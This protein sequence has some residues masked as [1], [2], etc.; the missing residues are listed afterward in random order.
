M[1]KFIKTANLHLLISTSIVVPAAIIYGFQ[2]A[3][4]FD[5]KL[6]TT[7]EQN[8]FKAI[9]GLYLAFA[10]VW[11]IGVFD[12]KYWKTA[13]I[14]NIFFMF[15][16]AFGRII[17]MIVDGVPSPLFVFGTIGEITLGAYGLWTIRQHSVKLT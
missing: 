14:C 2:P 15:G 16:L 12:E 6:N 4:L 7:D 8:I 10:S 13:T 9:M 3:L 5:V 11:I 1:K 17:S